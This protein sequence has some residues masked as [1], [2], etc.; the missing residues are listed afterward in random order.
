MSDPLLPPRER[1][2]QVP[3][4]ADSDGGG[5]RREAHGVAELVAPDTSNV[6]VIGLPV[7]LAMGPAVV[8]ADGG[9]LDAGT[10]S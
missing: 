4:R 5:V 3:D 7:T 1:S 10:V 6:P 8:V 9:E 2:R